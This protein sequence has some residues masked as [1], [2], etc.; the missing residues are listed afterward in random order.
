M[1]RICSIGSTAQWPVV[2][3]TAGTGRKTPQPAQGWKAKSPHIGDKHTLQISFTTN[4]NRQIGSAVYIA[5]MELD[6]AKRTRPRWGHC[7]RESGRQ[8]ILHTQCQNQHPLAVRT[9]ERHGSTLPPPSLGSYGGS[10]GPAK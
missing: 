3:S 2:I 10:I 8:V 7:A 5:Q 9:K 1:S 6:W 4:K